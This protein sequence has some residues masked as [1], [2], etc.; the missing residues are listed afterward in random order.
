VL[1]VGR[2][3]SGV[4]ALDIEHWAL[5]IG[6]WDR[7]IVGPFTSFFLRICISY[8]SLQRCLGKRCLVAFYEWSGTGN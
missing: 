8:F 1:N 7:R 4:G 3:A 5:S 6:P 2:R